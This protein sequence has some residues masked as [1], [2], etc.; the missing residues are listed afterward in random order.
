[1][2]SEDQEEIEEELILQDAATL[3]EMEK[4]GIDSQ[5]KWQPRV[6]NARVSYQNVQ[7]TGH[8]FFL[9]FSEEERRNPGNKDSMSSSVTLEN[10]SEEMSAMG[11]NG[12]NNLFFQLTMEMLD[13]KNFREWA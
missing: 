1:M 10:R 2:D 11:M 7:L 4:K 5:S 12:L 6:Q 13:G 3:L 8:G 9:E